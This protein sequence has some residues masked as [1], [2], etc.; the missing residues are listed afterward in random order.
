MKK[1][2]LTVLT[3]SSFIVNAAPTRTHDPH[4]VAPFS[5]TCKTKEVAPPVNP[6]D[7]NNPDGYYNLALNKT[8]DELK[9]TLNIIISTG[10]AKL[11][12]SSSSFDVWDALDIT[13]EDPNNSDNVIL[14]YT[15][16]SQAKGQKKLDRVTSGVITGT[17]NTPTLNPMA[18]SMTEVL[19]GIPI[20][21]TFVHPTK[22]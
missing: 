20:F 11:P 5:V 19:M 9:S 10:I 8:G 21:T 16:R 4:V 14:I 17:E 1:T 3:L 22:V 2:L 15:G 12:Y 6:G 18:A 13:D 7:I